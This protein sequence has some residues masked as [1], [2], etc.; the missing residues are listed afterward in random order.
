M[1]HISSDLL[2]PYI[3]Y[4]PNTNTARCQLRRLSMLKKILLV[5]V[6]LFSSFLATSVTFSPSSFYPR[7]PNKSPTHAHSIYYLHAFPTGLSS[8]PLSSPTLSESITSIHKT[9]QTSSVN[10]DGLAFTLFSCSP[11][12]SV[13]HL[14]ISLSL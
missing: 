10:S 3:I 11:E 7:L 2:S 4:L 5:M 1:F 8:T 13:S 6:Y 14:P 9:H 12:V